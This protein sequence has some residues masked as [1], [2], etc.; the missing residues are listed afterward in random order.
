MHLRLRKHASE[1]AKALIQGCES[2]DSGVRKDASEGVGALL[3]PYK[4]R[5]SYDK[6]NP[7]RCHGLLAVLSP[8][9]YESVSFVAERALQAV[10]DFF[11]TA[12][13]GDYW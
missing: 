5:F 4:A 6:K 12:P 9:C 2:I 10:D 11:S 8:L 1:S 13:G 3:L 7:G